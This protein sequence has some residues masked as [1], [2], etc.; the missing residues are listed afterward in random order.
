MHLLS[1]WDKQI[2]CEIKMPVLDAQFLRLPYTRDF[3]YIIMLSSGIRYSMHNKQLYVGDNTHW[4]FL[5]L[6]NATVS[7]SEELRIKYLT[8]LTSYSTRKQGLFVYLYIYHWHFLKKNLRNRG[9]RIVC[10]VRKVMVSDSKKKYSHSHVAVKNTAFPSFSIAF[11]GKTQFSSMTTYYSS[12][13]ER[14]HKS[15]KKV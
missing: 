8:V 1:N 5:P 4:E 15:T 12:P 11:S 6:M 3:K 9:L 2:V 13:R 10:D 7:T 14:K